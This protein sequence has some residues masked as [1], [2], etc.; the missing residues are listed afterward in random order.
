MQAG[1]WRDALTRL[2]WAEHLDPQM[3]TATVLRGI[4]LSRLGRW[5]DAIGPLSKAIAINPQ[6]ARALANLAAAYYETSQPEAARTHAEQALAIDSADPTA[7][8]VLSRMEQKVEPHLVSFLEGFDGPWRRIGWT[9]AILSL[10]TTIAL[11][12]HLPL[13]PPQMNTKDPLATI[14]PRTDGV[15]MAIVV[16]WLGLSLL[17]MTWLTIDLLDR[18]NRF[19]WLIPQLMCGFCGV[20]WFPLFVYFWIG[21]HSVR[22]VD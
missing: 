11:A 16:A 4:C 19:A 2:N 9:I 5:H 7:L 13:T 1:K 10:L 18:R 6:D 17:G 20:A 8:E 3:T 12:V 14:M 15:S 22:R 21:R